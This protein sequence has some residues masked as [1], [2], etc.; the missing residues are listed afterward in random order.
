E[1]LYYDRMARTSRWIAKATLA[2]DTLETKWKFEPEAADFPKDTETMAWFLERATSPS[3]SIPGTG[4]LTYLRL[5]LDAEQ[6]S[7]LSREG[8]TF[9]HG[10]EAALERASFRLQCLLW[11]HPM[12]FTF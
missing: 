4:P 9:T 6:M 1:T 7:R 12:C 11:S 8:H 10:D 5:L 3:R 2:V